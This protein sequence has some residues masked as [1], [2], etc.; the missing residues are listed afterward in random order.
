MSWC[1][2]SINFNGPFDHIFGTIIKEYDIEKANISMLFFAGKIDQTTYN[3]LYNSDRMTRQITVGNMIA[4][5]QEIF[6]TIQQGIYAAREKFFEITGLHSTS[7]I[8]IK[9]DAIFVIDPYNSIPDVIEVFPNVRFRVKNRYTD[10]IRF[11]NRVEL[12][13]YL[14]TINQVEYYDVKGIDDNKIG[15]HKDYMLDFICY[16]VSLIHTSSV[17]EA[18][19]TI[20]TFYQQYISMQS[21]LGYYRQFDVESRF[22]YKGLAKISVFEANHAQEFERQYIDPA[23]NAEI[24]RNL[25]R[26]ATQ[27]QFNK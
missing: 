2:K 18:I 14:D 11:V 25:Y 4:Q 1:S 19:Q 21:S 7:V 23:Y 5:D 8:S 9:N 27:L 6:K 17:M 3:Y 22:R 13:Y 10:Y 26:I 15:L 20:N 24:I 12:Y 16:I